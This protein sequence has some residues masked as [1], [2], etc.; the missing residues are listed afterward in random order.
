L[1]ADLVV[2]SACQTA[3]GREVRGEGIVG[4]THAFMQAGARGVVASLWKVPDRATSEL[5]RRFYE[6]VLRRGQPVS[7]A[8]RSAQLALRSTPR[9]SVPYAWAGFV[10]EGEWR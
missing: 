5:M 4:L 10:L 2:L 3:L 8:L 1:D 6:A 7:A 9:F